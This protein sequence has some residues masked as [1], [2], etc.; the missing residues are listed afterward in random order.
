MSTR[1]PRTPAAPTAWPEASPLAALAGRFVEACVTLVVIAAPLLFC[2]LAARRFEPLKVVF[3][4]G[5]A[6]V[7]VWALLVRALELRR[8]GSIPF[9]AGLRRALATPLGWAL[10]AFLGAHV[11]A[12]A[13]SLSPHVS[14]W[15]SHARLHGLFSLLSYIALAA[16]VACCIRSRAQVER[17]VSAMILT[18][19]PFA[20]LGI[21]QRF[22]VDP[23]GLMQ[24]PRRVAST[25]GAPNFAAA[26]VTMVLPLT[27][28]RLYGAVVG[29]ERRAGAPAAVGATRRCT[30]SSSRSRSCWRSSPRV[31]DRSSHARRGLPRRALPSCSTCAARAATRAVVPW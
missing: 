22:G 6:L 28:M 17:L 27:L 1:S 5:V 30:A 15:G 8:A 23:L 26:Y 2:N 10:F 18:S 9:V 11:L 20:L 31:A 4:R 3:V 24:D 19:V 13:F 12:T 21:G 16:G 7:A 25:L 29:T 14:V